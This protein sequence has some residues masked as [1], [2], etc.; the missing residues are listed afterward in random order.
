MAR[1]VECYGVRSASSDGT[2]G[3]VLGYF[4][5]DLFPRKGKYS[6]QCVYPLRPSYAK[7]G[8]RVLPACVNIGNLTPSRE[9]APSMLLFREVETFFHEVSVQ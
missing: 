4:Y 5:L 6:H 1:D 8:G 3:E 2:A 7:E 9:G